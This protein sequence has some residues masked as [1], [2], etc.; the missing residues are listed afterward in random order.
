M[1]AGEDIRL[2]TGQPLQG[3]YGLATQRQRLR[4]LD[5]KTGR[6]TSPAG[7]LDLLPF[8]AWSPDGR[9]LLIFGR[10]DGETWP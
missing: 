6:L 5:F 3:V 10:Q 8:L 4:L 1:E 2:T 9:A 7:G